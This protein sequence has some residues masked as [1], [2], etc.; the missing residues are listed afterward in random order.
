[1]RKKIDQIKEFMSTNPLVFRVADEVGMDV[2]G[3]PADA[4]TH[5]MWAARLLATDPEAFLALVLRMDKMALV[6]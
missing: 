3:W 4:S 6:T 5:Q 2:P 1:M